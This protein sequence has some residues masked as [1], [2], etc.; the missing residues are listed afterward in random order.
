MTRVNAIVLMAVGILMGFASA[1]FLPGA[2]VEAQAGSWQCKSWTLQKDQDA[3]ATGQWLGVT[4]DH[5][6]TSA[7]LSQSGMYTVVACRR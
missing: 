5:M 3:A 2:V 1:R 7:G 4:R 6:L